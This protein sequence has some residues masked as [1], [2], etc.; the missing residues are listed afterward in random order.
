MVF[1]EAL[2]RSL[3][4]YAS[5]THSK[6]ACAVVEHL[7]RG[8]Q[9]EVPLDRFLEHW[10]TKPEDQRS[11]P[12]ALFV[13]SGGAMTL[14]MVTDYWCNVGGP[15]PYH[16]SYTYSIYTKDSV[17]KDVTE[18]LAQVP[19]KGRWNFAPEVFAVFEG[20]APSVVQRA[21]SWLRG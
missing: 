17:E 5:A 1:D 8:S 20:R 3:T 6:E 15:M 12:Q 10:M 13:R 7:K 19:D 16:D 9:M 2:W 18:F 11:P 14:C 4:G 21:M